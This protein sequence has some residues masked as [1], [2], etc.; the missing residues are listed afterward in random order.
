MK[1]W[2]NKE[3]SSLPKSFLERTMSLKMKNSFGC[4]F[5]IISTWENRKKCQQNFTENLHFFAIFHENC[6]SEGD[7]K[8]KIWNRRTYQVYPVTTWAMKTFVVGWLVHYWCKSGVKHFIFPWQIWRHKR[9]CLSVR[10]SVGW[11]V[12]PS[13]SSW[14]VGKCAFLPLPTRPQLVAVYPALFRQHMRTCPQT[15]TNA[16]MY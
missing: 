10:W 15:S 16:L 5:L 1:K 11:S 12:G 6:L 2:K 8:R 14:K 9:P 7:L 13:Y 4:G 3:H